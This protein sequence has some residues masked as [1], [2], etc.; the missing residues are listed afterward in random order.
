MIQVRRYNHKNNIFYLLKLLNLIRHDKYL[1]YRYLC[2]KKAQP[3]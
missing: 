1:N 2:V 3:N